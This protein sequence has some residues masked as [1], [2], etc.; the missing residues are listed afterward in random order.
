L[1]EEEREAAHK[2]Q[3]QDE[4]VRQQHK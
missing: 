1:T 3:R 4:Q 2:K